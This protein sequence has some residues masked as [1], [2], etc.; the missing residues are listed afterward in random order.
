MYHKNLNN[1]SDLKESI[2]NILSSV[3]SAEFRCAMNNVSA[4]REA[5]LPAE[6]NNFQHLP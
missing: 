3:S 2:H 5:C 4:W 1:E 6:G